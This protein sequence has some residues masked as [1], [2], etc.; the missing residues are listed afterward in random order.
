MSI[1]LEKVNYSYLEKSN[2]ERAALREISLTIEEG[3]FLGIG[4][5]GSG[6]S[7]LMQHLNALLIPTSGSVLVDGHDTSD[8]KQAKLA[9]SL[10]GMVFQYPEYQLFDETV[11]KDIQFGPKNLGLSDEEAKDRALEAMELVGLDPAVFSELSPFDLSGGEKRRAALA[12][13]LAMKPKYLALDE[14]MAGLDPRGRREILDLLDSL[15]KSTGCSIIMIS[16]SMDDISRYAD[17]IAVM[18]HGKLAMLD[19]PSAVFRNSEFLQSIGLS[20]PCATILS[21]ALREK[22][23]CLPDGIVTMQSLLDSLLKEAGHAD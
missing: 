22:G 12:G 23:F 5:T 17:R 15:R 8:K 18:N 6:K 11:L 4:H 16:H 19:T 7:T 2:L 14:P 3:E 1:V 21:N 10:V 9:R 13:V 20:V